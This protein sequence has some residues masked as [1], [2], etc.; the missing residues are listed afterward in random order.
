[1]RRHPL[2]VLIGVGLAL[3]GCAHDQPTVPKVVYVT[4]TK[5]VPIDDALTEPCPKEMP[6]DRKWEEAVRVAH[7][8]G[9]SLDDCNGRMSEIRSI[10]H[11]AASTTEG[12]KKP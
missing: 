1:M 6:R 2:P 4:V 11:K 9:L 3:A 10:S 7:A 8:R 5:Y 12:E